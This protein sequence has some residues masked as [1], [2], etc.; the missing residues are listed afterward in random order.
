MSLWR[1]RLSSFAV[2]FASATAYGAYVLRQDLAKSHE[3]LL[4]Q[5]RAA[6]AHLSPP[7]SLS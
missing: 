3:Q 7:R 4:G 2:G 1:T 5:A 6:L